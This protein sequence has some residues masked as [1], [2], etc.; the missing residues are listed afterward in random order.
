M[1]IQSCLLEPPEPLEAG[2]EALDVPSWMT[3]TVPSLARKRN[4]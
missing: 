2:K 3:V 4:E 1:G